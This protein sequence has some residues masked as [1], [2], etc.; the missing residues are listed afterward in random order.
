MN[1]SNQKKI[2]IKDFK[3]LSVLGKGNYAKVLLVE[4][5]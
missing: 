1:Q 4:H 3:T 2:S 5:Q